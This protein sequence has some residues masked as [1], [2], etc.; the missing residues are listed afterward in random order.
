[1]LPFTHLDTTY[2]FYFRLMLLEKQNLTSFH[3]D[4]ASYSLTGRLAS[5][6]FIYYS[7]NMLPTATIHKLLTSSIK[8]KEAC[9]KANWF[10][11]Y[12]DYVCGVCI[13]FNA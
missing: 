8:L 7:R 1:M 4:L 10:T 3:I 12:T 9:T 2:I 5:A 13:A 11:V 6:F